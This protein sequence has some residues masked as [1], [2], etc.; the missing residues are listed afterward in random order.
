VTGP[1]AWPV[2]SCPVVSCTVY[3]A[4]L[5]LLRP[6]QHELLSPAEAARAARFRMQADRDR[7]VLA[8]GVLRVAAA[9]RTGGDPATLVVERGCEH[10]GG[11]HGRPRLPG[12]GLAASIS[13]SGDVVAVALTGG[14]PVGVDVEVITARDYAPLVPRV[15]AAA[16][17]RH[18]HTARDFYTVWTRKEAVLKATGAGL[19]TPIT[20]VTVT[21]PG[22]PPGVVEL[23][24]AEPACALADVEA[25]AGYAAAA[26]VLTAAAV[27]F[28][29]RDVPPL[30]AVG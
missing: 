12:T 11:Q 26:A 14:Q 4:R 2:V 24:G 29:V 20:S 10:C 15:C 3:L 17:R 13:H 30:L 22:Q 5:A 25:G 6:W 1:A 27:T 7:F 9:Q 8:T 28:D 19:R 18:V 21:P 16:E 23:A